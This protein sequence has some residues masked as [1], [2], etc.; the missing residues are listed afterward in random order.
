MS[1]KMATTNIK[2]ASLLKKKTK[3]EQLID[4]IEQARS[5]AAEGLSQAAVDTSNMV[6]AA[7]AATATDAA[8]SSS[9]STT[10][11]GAGA[12]SGTAAGAT[13]AGTAGAAAV[14]TGMVVAGVGGVAAV[15]AAAGGS[16]SSG[17]PAPT[18]EPT[19]TDTTA[20]TATITLS[21]SALKKGETATVTVTFSEVVTGFSNADL[22]LASGALSDMSSSD[23]GKTWTGTFTP[24]V[25]VEDATNVISLATTYTDA[26][27]NAGTTA[28]SANYAVDTKTP[29]SQSLAANGAAKTVTLTYNEALDSTN[30]PLTTAFD[31]QINGSANPVTLV[32]VNGMTVVLT[33]TNTFTTG[34]T[35]S[36]IYTD[37]VG[38]GTTT[39]QD[40]AG[41]DA[42]SFTSGVVA[43]GYIRDAQMYLDAPGGLV[44]LTGVKTDANGNFFL[45]QGINPNGYALV[46][47][48][49][50]N[51]DTGLPNTTQ[52]K[53]PAGSTTINPLTTLVQAVVES[54]GVTAEVAATNVATALGLTLPEGK[55][56]NNYDPLSATDGGAVA[57]QKAAAQ[58]ATLTTLAA[59]A[60]KNADGASANAAQTAATSVLTNIANV[61][62]NN[63]SVGDTNQKISFADTSVLTQVLRGVTLNESQQASV[64][65]ANTA[66]AAATTITGISTAQSQFVD[67]IAPDAPTA[68]S[69][70]ALTNDTTP[71]VEVKLNTKTTDGKAAVAG[72][73]LVIF[74][75]TTEVAN[76]TITAAHLAAGKVAI[77]L[78]TL[79]ESS[80]SLSAKLT[81]KAGNASAVSSASI[82]VVDTTGPSVV[83]S[84]STD[85]LAA[86]TSTT[87]TMTFS[88]AV[89]GL[90]ATDLQVAGSGAVSNLVKVSDTVYTATYTAPTTG[91]A[92]MVYIAADSYTDAAGNAGKVSNAINLAA[93]N[94]PVVTIN[95]IGGNDKVISAQT[96]DNI[97]S[98]TAQASNGDVTVKFGETTLGK[99][100]VAN[101][102]WSYTL[103]TENLSTIGQGTGKVI[104]A[105]QTRTVN[106]TDYKGT[107]TATVAVDTLVGGTSIYISGVSFDDM[108]I[109]AAEKAAG[110]V[111]SGDVEIG[112]IVQL[113]IGSTYTKNVTP[114]GAGKWSYTLTNSDF[115]QLKDN[116]NISAIAID[117]A[118]NKSLAVSHPYNLTIDTL[119]PVMG[120]VRL[121]DATDTGAKADGSTSSKTPSIEFTAES[122][123]DIWLKVG[124]GD[125]VKQDAKATGNTQTL[126]LSGLSEGVNAIAIKA[127]D[128]AGNESVRTSSIVMDSTAPTIADA[129]PSTPENSGADK[130]VYKATSSD[131][132]AVTYSLK[133]GADASSLSINART[134]EVKLLV[135]PDFEVKPS[136]SFTVVATDAAGNFSEK[137]VALNVTDVNEAPTRVELNGATT[138]IIENTLTSSAIKVSNITIADDAMGSNSVT[139]SG[140][141]AAYF[142]LGDRALYLKAGTSLDFETKNKYD[143]TVNVADTTVAGST[144]V[145][146]NYSLA[147]TVKV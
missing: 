56:L 29:L 95:S 79:T 83:I 89:T 1:A 127:I 35:V 75:G 128:A 18:P 52:M 78:P 105:E 38:D 108:V 132:S 76:V 48:G 139:L 84:S 22:T 103:T 97:V 6:A 116:T 106:G 50:V 26:A 121:S 34:Q 9:A 55:T 36:V 119:A 107:T 66:I 13:T 4:D 11:A 136:Y 113:T 146:A 135:N 74:D 25:D 120:L 77:D 14:S 98:G 147:V 61:V 118:G 123:A 80:H 133:E 21:D 115:N 71:A 64:V 40:T 15:A 47:V 3:E 39:I 37:A 88:E 12:A 82:G 63:A 45:P 85:I 102:V 81:D 140:A 19:A 87:L 58:I 17:T 144:P 24:T 41:N 131:T 138:S 72:D 27:G 110:L 60:A 137:A 111:V 101:G 117:A 96:G 28:S 104:T 32:T 141:D 57:A 7:P 30:I 65:E 114:D 94:P 143:V 91:D 90:T 16:S 93:V 5:E 100:T 23:G 122:G 142:E 10:T 62:A 69:I 130:I 46:A 86:G 53:A 44:E 109:N 49:G 145:S 43:D 134:G 2:T 70:A 125:Y 124:A 33:L 8:V 112:S 54:S 126:A 42:V 31:V 99:A 73:T 129:T 67:K 59:E 51:I 68:I 20:P 92:G